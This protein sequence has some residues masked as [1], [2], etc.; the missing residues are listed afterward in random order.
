MEVTLCTAPYLYPFKH[1]GI[2]ATRS[3]FVNEWKQMRLNA[4][5]QV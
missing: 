2:V 1:G 5:T 4:M 3:V